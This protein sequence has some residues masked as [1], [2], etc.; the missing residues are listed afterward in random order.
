MQNMVVDLPPFVVDFPNN[1]IVRDLAVKL[2]RDFDAATTGLP[3]V[4]R[5]QSAT[6]VITAD[7]ISIYFN[8][9][10]LD[11]SQP[12]CDA[13][14]G[15][16]SLLKFK[17]KEFAITGHVFY[18]DA[19][20]MLWNFTRRFGKSELM[21]ASKLTEI[22]YGQFAVG[23]TE[24]MAQI[25]QMTHDELQRAGGNPCAPLAFFMDIA[26]RHSHRLTHDYVRRLMDDEYILERM[27]TR[28]VERK[29]MFDPVYRKSKLLARQV[30]NTTEKGD[31]RALPYYFVY[32]AW[33]GDTGIILRS[34]TEPGRE[35]LD[36]LS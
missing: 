20:G 23:Q 17:P 27:D 6:G 30:D 12:L 15:A 7:G 29:V 4:Y 32:I 26:F 35:G 36:H 11:P 1:T 13:G 28:F 9:R 18:A 33:D 3:E 19:D 5:R 31:E 24:V 10:E 16:E 34:R 8:G 22:N 14:I 2:L 21:R 25:E